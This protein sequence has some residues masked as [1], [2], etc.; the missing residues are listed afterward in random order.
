MKFPIN[1]QVDKKRPREGSV[2]SFSD[3]DSEGIQRPH[4]DAIVLVL[5]IGGN[6]VKRVLVDTGS[7]ADILYKRAFDQMNLELRHL[8]QVRTPLVGFTGDTLQPLGKIPLRVEFG[9]VFGNDRLSGS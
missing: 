2:I 1:L 8:G 5:K 3:Q 7:S 9:P 6:R 4:D